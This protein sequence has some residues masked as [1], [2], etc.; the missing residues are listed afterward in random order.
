MECVTV[1]FYYALQI[2]L[3]RSCES[4]FGTDP[5]PEEVSCALG[6]L[7][8]AAYTA[9]TIG[10][11][12][13]LERFQWSLFIWG[14]ETRDPV[15]REWITI[16]LSD[17]ALKRVFQL[18]QEATSHSPVTMHNLRRIVGSEPR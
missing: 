5:V 15:H 6:S 3:H 16:H 17:P 10:P 4:A 12:Q 18:V 1:T 14:L 9:V 8:T 7:V 13:L 2:Y 11:I